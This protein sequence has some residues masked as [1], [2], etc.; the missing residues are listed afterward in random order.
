MGIFTSSRDK[1]RPVGTLLKRFNTFVKRNLVIFGGY[2]AS[3]CRRALSR[4]AGTRRPRGFGAIYAFPA[5]LIATLDD[6]LVSIPLEV[7]EVLYGSVRPANLAGDRGGTWNV[8]ETD[9]YALV[10]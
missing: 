6:L 2:G 9:D 1:T 10:V 5:N 4:L 3:H 7:R 8:A